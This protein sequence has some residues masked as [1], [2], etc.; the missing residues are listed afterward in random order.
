LEETIKPV[1]VGA[2]LRLHA[3]CAMGH[4]AGLENTRVF[5]KKTNPEVKVF[6]VFSVSRILL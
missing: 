5:K 2:G 3:S 1:A 6:R 4:K